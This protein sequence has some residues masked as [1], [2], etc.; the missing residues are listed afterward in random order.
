MANHIFMNIH[1]VIN[2]SDYWVRDQRTI[3]FTAK[4]QPKIWVNPHCP[5]LPHP[6][7]HPNLR[8]MIQR[9]RGG[10]LHTW[11][12]V[13]QKKKKKKKLSLENLFYSKWKEADLMTLIH[14]CKYNPNDLG[15][16]Q[17]R[18]CILGFLA[19]VCRD[20]QGLWCFAFLTL[21]ISSS[22]AFL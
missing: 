19:K 9:V 13:L 8:G 16:E 21:H 14:P 2:I 17:S 4:Y 20:T 3:L 6:H 1:R 11:W 12:V 15:K 10:F 18:P 5:Y 22:I 7:P